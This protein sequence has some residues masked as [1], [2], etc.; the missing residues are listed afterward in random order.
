MDGTEPMSTAPS[1]EMLGDIAVLRVSGDMSLES[2]IRAIKSGI[3]AS[4]SRRATKLL[5][6]GSQLGGF[7]PPSVAA[8]SYLTREW[9]EAAGSAMRI[10]YIGRA[11][12]VD[13]QKFE[14]TV[15]ASYGLVADIFLD[16]TDAL[17]WLRDD[18]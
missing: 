9:A 4:R 2:A 8:R 13:P 15:A 7:D 10:A 3:A 12:M 17:A 11:D 18:V 1:L 14:I 6:D 5:I 16:E